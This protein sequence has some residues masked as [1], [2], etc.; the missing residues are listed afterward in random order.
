MPIFSLNGSNFPYEYEIR[1]FYVARM[2]ELSDCWTSSKIYLMKFK[3]I[4][5]THIQILRKCTSSYEILKAYW[6]S[7]FQYEM[8]DWY[9][10][11]L[12]VF[13][14]GFMGEK[15]KRVYCRLY[16]DSSFFWFKNPDD[17]TSKGNVMLKV[18]HL[19]PLL[20]NQL[21]QPWTMDP[22]DTT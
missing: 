18:G 2:I 1:D 3:A 6:R 21:P 7:L 17:P 13:S 15:W 20:S 14:E 12:S 5:N 10:F 9:F 19:I 16:K 4:L 22:H 8:C 11:F